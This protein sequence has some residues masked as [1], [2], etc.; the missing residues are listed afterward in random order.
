MVKE[1]SDDLGLSCI[2]G[3]KALSMI[4][5]VASHALVFMVGGPVQNSNFYANETKLIQN[6]FLL[7]SPL[8]V[9]SFLLL[10]GFLFA[11]LL[12]LELEKRNGKINFGLLYIF[13]YI[14]L[15]PAYLAMITLYIT[16]MPK[17]GSGP[18]W[19]ARMELEK[20]RCTENMW[21]NLLYINNYVGN[22]KLV[23]SVAKMLKHK[24]ILSIDGAL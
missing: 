3:I 8:L 18:L 20:D 7:N 9:D 2:N 1:S 10:S 15:T 22:D 24:I 5:I 4:F 16:W 19:K 13:R 11:R 12:L 17:L 23:S 14:R 6:A 21:A